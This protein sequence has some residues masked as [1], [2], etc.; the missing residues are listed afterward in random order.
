MLSNPFTGQRVSLALAALCGVWLTIYVFNAEALYHRLGDLA[1]ALTFLAIFLGLSGVAVSFLFRGM[2]R[3]RRAL[4]TGEEV[5][6]RWQVTPQEWADFVGRSR[7]EGIKDRA[8]TLF[9]IAVF[10]VVIC[11]ALAISRRNR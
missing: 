1:H 10:S 5:F 9:L 11:G 3:V 4:A 7:P 8:M 2:A 6:G